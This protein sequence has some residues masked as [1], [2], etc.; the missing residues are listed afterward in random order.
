MQKNKVITEVAIFTVK[1]EFIAKIAKIR[2]GLREALKDF[3]GL[4]SLE[5]LMTAD[6][7]NVFADIAK[8]QTLA[9]AKAAAF[10]FESG[11]K[12]FMPYMNAIEE[13]KFMG[14]F[15]EQL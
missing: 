2:K 9:D 4:I 11:D 15:V 6:D 1:P 3:N 14:H 5:T 10:A 13:L 8:W 12:R 7:S